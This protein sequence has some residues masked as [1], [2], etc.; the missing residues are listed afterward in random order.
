MN[1]F[2]PVL[3]QMLVLFAFILIGYLLYKFKVM[4][5]GAFEVLSKL[6]NTVFIPALV[7]SAFMKDCTRDNIGKLW[8]LLLAS[9]A[10]M[11][12]IIPISLLFA[13]ITSGKDKFLK[14][15]VTYGFVFSNFGFMGYAVVNGL[16]PEIFT[17]YT[18][19]TLPFWFGIYVWGAPVL[20]MGDSDPEKNTFKAKLKN[21]INPMFIA[22]I[23][24]MIIG[25]SG[26]GAK[27]PKLV[28]DS[29]DKLG[30]CMSPIAMIIT[31]ITVAKFN[32]LK[33]MKK[34]W[35]YSVSLIRLI[36]F[37][38][39]YLGICILI[40]HM[41]HPIVPDA[42][43][44]CGMCM[45]AMPMGLNTIVIP[46]AYGKDTSQAAVLAIVTHVLSVI[47]IPVIFM[48]FEKIV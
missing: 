38:I 8:Q 28:V 24:G 30:N 12:I 35:V 41:K 17:Q 40:I 37:P 48:I 1:V 6:E 32:I 42:V 46:A 39:I 13:K 11:F 19:F 2:I 3:G 21:I 27:M 4:S 45:V 23:I 15:I 10:L 29:V 22:M 47:T 44:K 34:V 36:L 14:Q 5:D 20:L 31:G 7:L 9:F 18:V 33:Y 16:F 26:L 43:L 25:L